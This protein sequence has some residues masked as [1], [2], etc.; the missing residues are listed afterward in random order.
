MLPARRLVF[1]V[2]L[3][4]VLPATAVA[5]P[6]PPKPLWPLTAEA[7]LIVVAEVSAVENLP[8]EEHS[9][10]S[11]LARLRVSKT[12]KGPRMS[13]VEVP[14]A[15]GLICPAPPRYAVDE[16]VVAF[17]RHEKGSWRTASLSYGTLYPQ[18]ADLEDVLAMVRAAL[19]IQ[20]A[21]SD[22]AELENRKR[23]W[24]VQA[25]ALP[26]TRWH[27]LHGLAP[28]EKTVSDRGGQPT[29]LTI[30]ERH[31]AL[32]AEAFIQ[33]PRVDHTFP[34]MLLLLRGVE[35]PRVD[36]LALGVLEDQ[37]A[38]EE[39]RFPVQDLLW[40]VLERWGDARPRA[41][42]EKLGVDRWDVT[43]EH[44]RGIWSESKVELDIP[45]VPVPADLE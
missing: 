33:A 27:G 19:A 6:I 13:L 7:E 17:L 34:T 36:E 9:L 30:G 44:L 31:R 32:L 40:A 37:L 21:V 2:V 10:V 28:R 4:L 8:R 43:R 18:G 12:L 22:V 29:R 24:L 3:A 39:S 35:D 14:Y 41:R 25:A 23:E 26:G 16:T 15:A 38:G 45:D 20:G 5:Y 1:P 42:L 11:A